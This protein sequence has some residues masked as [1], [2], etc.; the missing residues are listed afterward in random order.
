MQGED[1][2]SIEQRNAW[3]Q[4]RAELDKK[5]LKLIHHACK[6]TQQRHVKALEYAFLLHNAS[7]VELAVQLAHQAG[8]TQLSQRLMALAQVKSQQ[9]MTADDAVHQAHARPVAA[10]RPQPAL[11]A[12]AKSTASKAASDSVDFVDLPDSP[13][14][15]VAESQAN[16][17]SELKKRK[18]EEA[19]PVMLASV[20]PLAQSLMTPAK[21]AKIV[22]PNSSTKKGLFEF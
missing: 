20:G 22:D 13:R 7:S 14:A 19:P 16:S 1:N 11:A 9:E 18:A 6:P 5:L 10:S 3:R 17:S 12:P 4:A 15:A 21:L 2:D 8:A